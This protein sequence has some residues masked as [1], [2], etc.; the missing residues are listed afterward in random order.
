MKALPDVLQVVISEVFTSGK[1]SLW[2]NSKV[3]SVK[4]LWKPEVVDWLIW[5]EILP[6]QA[7]MTSHVHFEL[8]SKNGGEWVVN[9]CKTSENVKHPGKLLLSLEYFSDHAKSF[10]RPQQ[11]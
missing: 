10:M 2:D 6:Q 4:L 7:T 11:V 9:A 3:T 1:K 5:S 8:M